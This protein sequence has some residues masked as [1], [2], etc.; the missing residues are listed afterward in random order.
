M[1]NKEIEKLKKVIEI[2]KECLD[3]KITCISDS[4]SSFKLE[5]KC[6]ECEIGL[7]EFDL[8]YKII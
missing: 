4:E 8:L 3:L 1:I 5:S 7:Y 2:L 6:S